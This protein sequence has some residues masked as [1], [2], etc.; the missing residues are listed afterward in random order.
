M[1]DIMLHVLSLAVGFGLGVWIESRYGMQAAALNA[2]I[3]AK[4]DEIKTT[5]ARKKT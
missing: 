4:L 5:L 1:T 2:E 3:H